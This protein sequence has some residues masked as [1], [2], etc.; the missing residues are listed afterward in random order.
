MY[1]LRAK[2]FEEHVRV[3][4]RSPSQ[5]SEADTACRSVFQGTHEEVYPVWFS[6][7]QIPLDARQKHD[8][9]M[10]YK[11]LGTPFFFFGGGGWGSLR[12]GLLLRKLF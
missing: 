3:L 6:T 8:I 9:L 1:R 7:L 5:Q 11:R 4:K 2:G 10:E 12:P